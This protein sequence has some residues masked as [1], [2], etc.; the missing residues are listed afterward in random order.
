MITGTGQANVEGWLTIQGAVVPALTAGNDH[1]HGGPGGRAQ[2]Y[3]SVLGKITAIGGDTTNIHGT[4]AVY[5]QGVVV[6]TADRV[7]V[8]VVCP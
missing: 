1:G 3:F 6:F 7:T 2:Q 8:D 4:V 5:S